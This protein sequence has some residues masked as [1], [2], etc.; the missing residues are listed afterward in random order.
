MTQKTL[1]VCHAP[2]CSKRSPLL[3]YPLCPEH[4]TKLPQETRD[5]IAAGRTEASTSGD[6][7][8]YDAA[9]SSAIREIEKG[10]R[11]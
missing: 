8:A 10:A 11:G 2:D 6:R 1:G 9:V 4:F 7:S 5:A 3:M